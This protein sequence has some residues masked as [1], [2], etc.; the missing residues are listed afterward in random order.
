MA[1]ERRIS[2]Q[3]TSPLD[4]I[5]EVQQCVSELQVELQKVF[6]IQQAVT[7]RWAA[8]EIIQLVA[9]AVLGKYQA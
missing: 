3:G 5:Q 1:N 4:K 9:E 8:Q 6:Q 7:E 2:S